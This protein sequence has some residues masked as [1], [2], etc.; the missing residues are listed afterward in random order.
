MNFIVTHPIAAQPS[1]KAAMVKHR[2][3]CAYGPGQP[4]P[5][6]LAHQRQ[7]T[8]VKV[9]YNGGPIFEYTCSA[10]GIRWRNA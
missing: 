10:C 6:N 7:V 2:L 8:F 1:D 5:E 3:A 9:G 4:T